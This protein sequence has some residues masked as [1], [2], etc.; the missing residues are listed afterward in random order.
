MGR[1]LHPRGEHTRPSRGLGTGGRCH[2][3]G[4][5]GQSSDLDC[6][7]RPISR[8]AAPGP[9]PGSPESS[10]YP[11]PTP[12]G[13][14]RAL[15]PDACPARPSSGPT[16]VCRVL[17]A[18]RRGQAH[19]SGGPGA[20]PRLQGGSPGPAAPASRRPGPPLPHPD[21]LRQLSLT[22][23]TRTRL[24][25]C[26]CPSAPSRA[27]SAVT[28][29]ENWGRLRGEGRPGPWSQAAVRFAW[30]GANWGFSVRGTDA[31]LLNPAGGTGLLL[32]AGFWARRVGV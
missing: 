21:S 1:G 19:D 28:W 26:L 14:G 4:A 10:D 23:G 30:A 7:R 31:R 5:S 9:P 17:G 16:G 18:A 24:G 27:S 8:G 22:C 15:P 6:G 32:R 29:M 3:R 2:V 11:R 25:A 20:G 12:G 13:R